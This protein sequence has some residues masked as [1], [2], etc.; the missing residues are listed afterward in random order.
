MIKPW[1]RTDQSLTSK[2]VHRDQYKNSHG[3]NANDYPFH[4][5]PLDQLKVVNLSFI[6]SPSS[7]TK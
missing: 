5:D 6:F 3:K 7:R 4:F 2:E 1:F